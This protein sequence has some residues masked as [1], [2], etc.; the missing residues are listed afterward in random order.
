MC[1]IFITV[2]YMF[3]FTEA[4][5]A[6]PIPAVA[7]FAGNIAEPGPMQL[8]LLLVMQVVSEHPLAACVE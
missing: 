1:S 2:A 7:T 5:P 6:V 3:G 8:V 4:V